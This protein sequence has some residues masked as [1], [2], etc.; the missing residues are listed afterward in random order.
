MKLYQAP[1][2][3]YC[4]KVSLV[5]A[6]LGLEDRIAFVLQ[7]PRDDTNGFH[8][9]AP[10]A[11]IPA[12]QTYEGL[13]LADSTVICE[14]LNELA[15]GSLFPPSGAARW[16]AL[17]GQAIGDGLLDTLLPLRH[18]RLR[19]AAQQSE[20]LTKRLRATVERVLDAL[21][22][23][24]PLDRSAFTIGDIAIA[25][26]LGYLDFHFPELSWRTRR[27]GLERWF[28]DTARR[29]SLSGLAFG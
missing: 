25:T 29:A 3:P 13:V 2:S 23:D 20:E 16:R 5:C 22:A 21:E 4:K 12:L 9:R 15:S 19:S 14:Y 6:E 24:W 28:R 18:E 17:N 10:L 27:E 1:T 8:E 11:R 7:M 26:A